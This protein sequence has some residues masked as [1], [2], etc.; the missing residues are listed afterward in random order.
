MTTFTIKIN[1]R[2]K[3]GKAFRAMTE[4][5]FKDAK[6]IEII[7]NKEEKEDEIYNP[8]FVK[9]ILERGESIND[10]EKRKNWKEINPKD[11]WG[12]LK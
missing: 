12:S 10:S 5:F 8:E 9:M 7:E 3:A 4:T 2:T 1:E 11:L 6:G